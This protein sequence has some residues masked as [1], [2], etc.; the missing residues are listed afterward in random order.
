[1]TKDYNK[2][3]FYLHL[4]NHC[5]V[6]SFIVW[7]NLSVV[8]CWRLRSVTLFKTQC[9]IR[10][11][12]R[13]MKKKGSGWYKLST[14][15]NARHSAGRVSVVEL[16]Q[17]NKSQARRHSRLSSA[18]KCEYRIQHSTA[19]RGIWIMGLEC[20]NGGE[21]RAMSHTTTIT[22]R[23]ALTEDLGNWLF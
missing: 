13:T 9:H 19:S 22:H 6:F 5:Q 1:M 7:T 18:Y 20:I 8:G 23:A 4:H 12:N 21:G 15:Y 16:N 3:K 11:D 10:C 17:H 14:A 2:T